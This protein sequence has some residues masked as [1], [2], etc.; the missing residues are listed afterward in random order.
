MQKRPDIS[1]QGSLGMDTR[2][3]IVA[4]WQVEVKEG[5]VAKGEQLRVARRGRGDLNR[6]TREDGNGP[7]GPGNPEVERKVE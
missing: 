7:L 6:H 1:Q 5:E 2:V 3:A 4:R